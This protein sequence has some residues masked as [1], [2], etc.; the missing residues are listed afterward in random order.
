MDPDRIAMT[1][2]PSDLPPLT[3]HE[4]QSITRL[5]SRFSLAPQGYALFVGAIEPKTNLRRLIEAFL[6]ID[7]DLP[8]VIV[9]R[10]A[11]M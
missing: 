11:W 9:C 4:R 6:E 1:W 8:L 7:S 2:Q 10:K 5:L 3:D